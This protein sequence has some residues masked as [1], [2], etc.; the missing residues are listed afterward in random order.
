MRA[1]EGVDPHPQPTSRGRALSL[2]EGRDHRAGLGLGVLGDRVLE[3]EEGDVGGGGGGLLHL[4][5]A[6]TGGEQ[7]RA[8]AEGF[9]GGGHCLSLVDR[10][11]G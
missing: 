7:Q 3:V 6:V 4:P 9:F 2:E 11:P 10:R 1:V 8:R 5:V